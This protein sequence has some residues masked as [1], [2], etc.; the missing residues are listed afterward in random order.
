MSLCK[1]DAKD[2]R[3]A[4]EG[5]ATL[6]RDLTVMEEL[7]LQEMSVSYQPEV[8]SLGAL[9]L[10]R[11]GRMHA[12]PIVVVG[13]KQKGSCVRVLS[14]DFQSFMNPLWLKLLSMVLHAPNVAQQRRS[15][16]AAKR[17]R[18]LVAKQEYT[19]ARSQVNTI[20]SYIFED[21]IYSQS[22]RMAV[23]Y[24]LTSN[25]ITFTGNART[26]LWT[27]ITKKTSSPKEENIRARVMRGLFAKAS[28]EGQ[29]SLRT[30]IRQTQDSA[31]DDVRMK[32]IVRL[33]EHIN[34]AIEGEENWKENG[35]FSQKKI[36]RRCLGRICC[37]RGWSGTGEKRGNRSI[38]SNC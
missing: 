25:E 21:D 1:R 14:M 4:F 2:D 10:A 29:E 33:Q 35:I 26:L 37:G 38:T 22:E 18:K 5:T 27:Q 19:I 3:D 16:D 20:I 17:I 12:L 24:I 13:G 7:L 8:A 9:A 23:R 30:L 15:K 34:T 36:G 11:L 32:G 28:K 6:D 31:F